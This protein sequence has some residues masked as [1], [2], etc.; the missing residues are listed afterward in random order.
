VKNKLLIILVL[1]LGSWSFHNPEPKLISI[2]GKTQGTTFQVS[3]YHET[4]EITR[5][6]IDSILLLV[7]NSMSLYKESSLISEINRSREGGVLDPHFLVVMKKAIEINE[8]TNGIFDV[9]VGPLVAAWGFSHKKP[10]A[11]PNS[12]TIAAIMPFVGM[13]FIQLQNGYLKKLKPEIKID[14]NGI[15]QG[16]TVDLISDFLLEQGIEN[17]L[18]EIGG[19]LRVNGMK[20]TSKNFVIGIEGPSNSYNNEATIKHTV[21]LK[22]QALTTSGSYRNYLLRGKERLSHIIDPKTGYPVKT[23]IL[24][25]TVA[26]KDAIT[27]DGYD[28]A[29]LAMGVADAI[30]FVNARPE[31]EAYFVYLNNENKVAD[32]MSMGFRKLL[33]N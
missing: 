23:D 29:L 27:A 8:H 19:E 28:N 21:V 26:A 16:Y 32:T 15:A 22:D 13:E 17:F 30:K 1:G 20:P 10:G 3:Y 24:S 9:T 14:L 4:K 2:R 5:S 6:E 25:A 7:D 33:R 31:I 18:V 12:T 11:L